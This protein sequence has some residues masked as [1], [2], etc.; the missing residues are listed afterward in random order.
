MVPVP[1]NVRCYSN[2]DIIVPPSE[3]TRWAKWR[4]RPISLDD[5]IGNRE[6]GRR[7]GQAECLRGLQVDDQLEL[8]R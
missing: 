3:V 8:C 7:D 5:L 4:H 1:I 2:N 6:Q